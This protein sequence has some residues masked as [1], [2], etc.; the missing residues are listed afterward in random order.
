MN[1]KTLL[2][3]TLFVE[4]GLY[5]FGLLLIG[6]SSAFQSRFSISWSGTGYALLLSIPMF[7]ALFLTIRSNWEPLLHLRNEMEEKVVP[8]F[9]NCK[10]ID[11]AVIAFL[12]G[13]GEELFFRG[14]MQNALANQFGIWAGI[15]VASLIFGLAHYLSN[16]YFIYAFFTG[17]YL[18]VI[19]QTTGNLYIVMIIHAMYDF[20]ALIFLVREGRNGEA[21]LLAG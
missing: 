4:G 16:T 12:A 7:A 11:L 17:I 8:I 13:F 6:G 1:R 10:I 20:I 2:L 3:V 15:L 18:G 9:A 21:D 14:W 5:L 19:Y